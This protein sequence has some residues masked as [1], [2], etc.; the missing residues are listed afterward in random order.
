MR[1]ALEKA[2]R[3]NKILVDRTTSI[4]GQLK[5]LEAEAKKSE[6]AFKALD[7]KFKVL[8]RFH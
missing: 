1:I 7:E 6:D 4:D 2:E 8:F 3:D 5:R